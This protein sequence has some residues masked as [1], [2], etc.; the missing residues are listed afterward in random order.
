ML[1]TDS[2][3]GYALL[4]ELH[5]GGQGVVYKAVQESTRR[6]VAIKVLHERPDGNDSARMRFHREARVLGR[7]NHPNIVTIHDSGSAADQPYFVMDYVAGVSLDRYIRSVEPSV[8]DTLSLF[9]TICDAVHEAHVRG[10]IHRDLKPGNILVDDQGRPR[11]LDFGLAKLAEAE[12]MAPTVTASGQFVGSLPWSAPEQVEGRSA[13]VDTRTDVYSLGV[14]FYQMLTGRFPYSMAGT[15]HDVMNRILRDDPVRP[16]T[17]RRGIDDELDTI[18]RKCLHKERARR[19]DNAGHLAR[20]L[21]RY[22]D[23]EPIEAKRDSGWY[24]FRKAVRRHRVPVAFAA[25]VAF[26]GVTAIAGLLVA[27]TRQSRLRADAQRQAEIA[28]AVNGFLN[29]DLLAA[30]KP[31]EMGRDV[32]VREV[33]DAASEQIERRFPDQPVVE[34]AVRQTLGQT[35]LELGEWEAALRHAERALEVNRAAL[36]LGHP[37]TLSA[38]QL[39]GRLYRRVGRYHEAE[40]ILKTMVASART[41][42]GRK[43]PLTTQGMN[44]L[45]Y[46]L[47]EL[48]RGR[49]ALAVNT[50]VLNIRTAML[51]SEHPETL[52]SLNNQA[53]YLEQLGRLAEAEQLYF[54]AYRLREKVLGPAH[55]DTLNSMGNL[56]NRWTGMDR[57]E[58]AERLHLERLKRSRALLGE[59]HPE[60]LRCLGMLG[61]LYRR[62]G[63]YEEAETLLVQALDAW[64]ELVGDSHR[65]VATALW[66]LGEVFS[67]QERHDEAEATLLKALEMHRSTVGPQ[68]V[69]TSRIARVLARFYADRGRYKDAEPLLTLAVS[70]LK[71]ALGSHHEAYLSAQRD[72]ASLYEA[73]HAAE[74]ASASYP[75]SEP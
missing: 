31:Q 4:S 40:A 39:V 13:V 61:D 23:G 10:I 65:E 51:G 29:Q 52:G 66:R 57:W 25:L 70:G 59:R 14:V 18:V 58:D 5:R 41:T 3:E 53:Y 44:N 56:A 11:I 35:Y 2:I 73:W 42:L 47:D 38:M 16:G 6:Q 24:V 63:R 33:L 60:V 22:L 30:V 26:F 68:H 64:R 8:K 49:E 32:T 62:Q 17:L 71:H 55:P 1:R 7:L 72:L 12:E 74:P 45:A 48:A 34:A 27:H 19:Y 21:R 75:A 46:A 43:H 69:A 28:Q 54:E 67:C 36:G 20:D 37:D 9:V 50:E 15:A